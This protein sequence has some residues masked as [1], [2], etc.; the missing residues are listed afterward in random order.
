M[1]FSCADG[2][3]GDPYSLAKEE[4]CRPCE[5]NSNIDSM[6]IGN[7]DRSTGECLR[8]IGHTAGF[9]CEQCEENHWGSALAHTCQPCNCHHRGAHTLQCNNATGTCECRE[10]Y[11]GKRCDRCEI[12]HGD[13]ENDCP[14]CLCDSV[15]SLGFSCDEVSGQCSCKTGVYGKRC[16][17][18]IPKYYNFTDNGCQYCG[19]DEYGSIKGQ[20]CDTVTGK[21]QCLRNVEGVKCERCAQ[22]FFNISSGTGC[23]PCGCSEL[24]AQGNECRVFEG[25]CNCKPGVTGLKCDKCEPNHYGLD[26]TGCKR[27][28]ALNFK[29]S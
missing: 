3:F 22:G 8:C 27:E 9:N 20:E 19:C 6:A 24:G 18:C 7:C 10:N 23:E 15:G 14:E 25:Q 2:Y 26:E 28:W 1:K 5:C 16:D 17:K 11:T 12:G 13:V 21:C 4:G 29:Y